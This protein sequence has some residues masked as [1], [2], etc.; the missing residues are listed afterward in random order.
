MSYITLKKIPQLILF[1][2]LT[3]LKMNS[4][5]TPFYEQYDW[6]DEPLSNIKLDDVQD[7]DIVSF[8]DKRV[9][10]FYFLEKNALVEYLLIHKM[11][12]LNSNDKIEE[13]N[14]VYLPYT[15]G[16]EVI[17]NKARVINKEGKIQELDKSKILTSKNEETKSEQ[18][19]YAL[20]GVEK[21]SFIEYYYVVKKYPIYTGKQEIFQ[22][23]LIKKNVAFDL[24]APKNLEFEMK[25]YNGLQDMVRDTI[26]TEKNHW[27]LEIDQLPAL[28]HEEQSPYKT[29]TQQLIYKLKNN[30]L[31]PSKELVSYRI[32]AQNIFNSLYPEIDS[33]L[34][35]QLQKFIASM[36]KFSIENQE[37]TVRTIE[38]FVKMSVF[39]TK[40][41]RKDLQDLSEIIKNNVANE[42]GMMQL[43]GAIFNELGIKHQIV[44][45][46]NR[47]DLKFDKKF[48]AYN[49]LH[50]YLIYFPKTKL[51]M[52][53]TRQDS[54]L[55]FPP[56]YLTDNYGLFI[57]PV[58]L[59]G[60]TTGIGQIKYIKPTGYQKSSY[61]LI[62]SVSFD[63]E[64]M[65]TTHLKM[66]RMM[67]GYYALYIQPFAEM[68]KEEDK[69]EIIDG[70][71]KSI[72][73]NIEIVNKEVQNAT[74][75]DFG[76]KPLKIVAD[77]TSD[78]F[79][80]KAGNK[81][82]F[83][84]GE[85]IGTQQE[86]YQDKLRKLPVEQEYKR[87][88]DRK[89]IVDIPPGYIFKNLENIRINESYSKDG[90]EL[91]KFESSYEIKDNQLLVSIKEYYDLNIIDVSTY[92]DYRRIINSAAN[93]NKITLILVKEQQ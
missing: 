50:D 80:E 1:F 22:S 46:S 4:Q 17:R 65:T 9:H 20:E 62:M 15:A 48:E 14:R 51:Y 54:R 16:S 66:Q 60:F 5:E 59:G 38:N 30:T 70:I 72:N 24:Y 57:K 40:V 61:D 52:A 7:N 31:T 28:D 37:A 79:V 10:E 3:F 55:G 41:K 27:Q 90:K 36:P 63:K 81:Y 76:N 83:K 34:K 53:P 39:M 88:F 19:Y 47:L 78:F 26:L 44:L 35:K 32:G 89:I 33:K 6:S 93:F 21:G 49:F 71:L 12:W 85:I 8:K 87:N 18:K 67:S 45:T 11:Y 43:Y 13:Y 29:K 77:L 73:E 68:M 84:L 92:E 42:N 25:S 74:P 91:L 64:D 86:M 58:T 56:G 82:L 2:G 69:E 75:Q 23:D